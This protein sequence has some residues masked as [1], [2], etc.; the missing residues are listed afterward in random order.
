MYIGQI[1]KSVLVSKK[2]P[3]TCKPKNKESAKAYSE[4]KIGLGGIWSRGRS[5]TAFSP[6]LDS[7]THHPMLTWEAGL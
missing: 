7:S 3:T 5:I 6:P 4:S 2:I 1:Y